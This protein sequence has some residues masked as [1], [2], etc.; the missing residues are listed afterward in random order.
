MRLLGRVFRRSGLNCGTRPPGRVILHRLPFPSK[1]FPL[2]G[3]GG[4]RSVTDEGEKK[5]A[6]RNSE[7]LTFSYVTPYYFVAQFPVASAVR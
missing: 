5:P 1:A 4:T 2:M 3:E 7:R 6:S